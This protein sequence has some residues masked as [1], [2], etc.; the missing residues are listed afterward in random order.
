MDISEFNNSD[1]YKLL[2]WFYL[3]CRMRERRRRKR[4]RE[5]IRRMTT[6]FYTILMMSE[7]SRRQPRS[8]NKQR[9]EET[10]LVLKNEASEEDFLEIFRMSRRDF[11]RLEGILKKRLEPKTNFLSTQEPISTEKQLASALYVLVTGRALKDAQNVFGIARSTVNRSVYRVVDALIQELMKEEIVMPSEEECGWISKAFKDSCGIPQII[12]CLGTT[13]IPVF[14]PDDIKSSYMNAGHWT[15]IILQAVVDDK[16]RL[17]NIS[18][19]CPGSYQEAAVLMESKLFESHDSLIPNTLEDVG[20]TKI[21]Y[22]IVGGLAYPHLSWL[23]KDYT[24][25]DTASIAFN[26]KLT[27]ARKKIDSTFNSLKARFP[28]LQNG[29]E[30]SHEFFP[31]VVI[32]LCILH[33][34][35]LESDQPDQWAIPEDQDLINDQPPPDLYED[36]PHPETLEIRDAL[37]RHT[38]FL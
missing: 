18:V 27:K 34:F 5:M 24:E 17:R 25:T 32:A 22:L 4:F 31:N 13:H 26:A 19:N 21:P 7:A 38:E 8:S 1:K 12:G 29:S 16:G 37:C 2:M 23:I 35:L 9:S 15:S 14:T 6:N 30:K 3:R 28:I 20:G 33:N 36:S 11:Y 10:W